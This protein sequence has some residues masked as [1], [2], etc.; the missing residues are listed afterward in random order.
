ME[1]GSVHGLFLFSSGSSTPRLVFIEHGRH[2]TG[3]L[4]G[5]SGVILGRADMKLKFVSADR[6]RHTPVPERILL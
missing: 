4:R 1:F 5:I 3:A 2:L 6:A